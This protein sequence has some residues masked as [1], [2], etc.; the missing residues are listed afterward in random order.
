MADGT[1][2]VRAI[3]TGKLWRL[4]LVVGAIIWVLASVI[5]GVTEDTILLP[6]VVR[7]GAFWCRSRWS[8]SR[9]RGPAGTT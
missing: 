3:V 2:E 8:P 5:T 4:L 6:C 9:S 7:S 1:T